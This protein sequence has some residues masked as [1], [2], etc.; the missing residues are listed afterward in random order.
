[1]LARYVFAR[2][3]LVGASKI[4]GGCP[5]RGFRQFSYRVEKARV[6]DNRPGGRS[7]REMTDTSGAY[8]A[9]SGIVHLT[10]HMRQSLKPD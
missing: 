1:M 9:T 5:G 2:A 7:A 3:V 8:G 4:F 10:K 6:K